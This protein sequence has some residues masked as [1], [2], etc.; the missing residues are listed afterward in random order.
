M[1]KSAKDYLDEAKSQINTISKQE[2][3]ALDPSETI[4]VDVRPKEAFDKGHIEGA[5]HAERG[6]LEFYTD[7]SHPF[8]KPELSQD[9]NIVVY[10]EL[11]GQSALSSKLMQD[12]GVKKVFNLDGGYQS[13][14]K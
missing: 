11:G 9:K 14:S 6:L 2:A 12:M 3:Q 8:H 7:P 10:C 4:F 5:V 1:P 13:W